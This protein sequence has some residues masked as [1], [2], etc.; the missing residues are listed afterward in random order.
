MI[1]YHTTANA[2]LIACD[3]FRDATRAFG[4]VELTGV[5]LG[6]SPMDVNEG[7]KGVDVLQIKFPDLIDVDAYELVEEGKPYREWCVPAAL[8]NDHAEVTLLTDDVLEARANAEGS[9]DALRD[10]MAPPFPQWGDFTILKVRVTAVDEHGYY[11]LAVLR[12]DDEDGYYEP[13]RCNIN[14]PEGERQGFHQQVDSLYSEWHQG[15]DGWWGHWW[16]GRRSLRRRG[17]K[18]REM[19]QE[20]LTRAAQE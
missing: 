14:D 9:F 12:G 2:C 19:M 3:G 4:G 8:I 10:S 6:D 11:E 13:A 20:R 18:I 17:W 1:Y 7:A 15:R 16:N 5:F